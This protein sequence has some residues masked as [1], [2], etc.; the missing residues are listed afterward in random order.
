MSDLSPSEKKLLDTLIQKSLDS[1]PQSTPKSVKDLA[2]T[3]AQDIAPDELKD[4][5]PAT[6]SEIALT[7]WDLSKKRVKNEAEL[8][9][10]CPT[11]KKSKFHKTIID[12]VCDDNSF[13]IDSVIAEVN[14]NNYLIDFLL[15]PTLS[16][17][18]EKDG[19]IK[20]LSR[21][22]DNDRPRQAHVHIQIN[23]ALSEAAI[24]A[25]EE[26]LEEV[27]AD[28]AVVNRDWKPMLSRLAE[29]REAL[30][31]ARTKRP[32]REIEKYCSFLDYLYDNNFTLLAYREYE[33][34]EKDGELKSRTLLGKS[35]GLLSKD[36]KPAFISESK[37]GLPRNLQELRRKLDPVSVSKT[38]RLST[39]H[40]RVPMDAIAIK[41]YDDDG[42]V[43]GEKLFLGLFTSVTY[44]RSVSSVP[45]LREKVEDVIELSDF[46]PGS[47]DR[48]ALR[49]ILEKYPRDELFQIE[50]KQLLKTAVSILRLQEKQRIALFTRKDPFGRYISCLIY[51]PRDR[52]SSELRVRLI[53]ILEDELQGE[54][55]NFYTNMDDSVFARVA[56]TINIKQ[57]KSARLN[58]QE[59]EEKLQE[60]GKTWQEKLSSALIDIYD[61]GEKIVALSER[62]MN[63]FPVSYTSRYRES[64]AVFDIEHIEEALG[65][66]ILGLDLYKPEDVGERQLRL[67]IYNP[68]K[69][70]TLSDI[71]PI[72]DNM[73]LRAI[74]EL[75]Y[76][77]LPK[78][79]QTVW[80]HDFLLEAPEIAKKISIDDVK[81]NFERA[82]TKIWYGE[83]ESDGLNRLI[84]SANMNWH[85][86]T[87]LRTYVRYLKQLRFPLSKPYIEKAL[88]QHPQNSRLLV[89]LFKAYH[90][91][92]NG[93]DSKKRVHAVAASIEKAL[94]D[95]DS[96]DQDRILRTIKEL[97]DA[98]LRTN[99]YQRKDDGTAK[100]YLSVKLQCKDISVLPE[101][102]PYVEIFV[103]SPRV[104]GV[105]LRGD[106]IARGGLRWSDRHEDF[107]TEVLGLMKAQMVKNS[108][109][110]PMGAKGGFIVKK[111]PKE[112]EQ[113]QQE[114]IECYK[115]F[116]RGLLDITDNRKEGKT[117]PPENIVRRD[118]DDPYLVVAADKGTAKF[119]D[120]ANS[121]SEEYDFWLGDAFASGGSVGYDH[122]K[123]G[124]TARG[125][126]ES[127]KAHFRM[128]N[129]NTQEQDFDVVGVGDM[130]GDVFGNG[131]L[132]SRHIRLVAAFNH[133][134]IF[135]DPD[136]DP[137]ASFEE[138]KKLFEDVCGWDS[139]DTDKLSK[140]GRIF[141]RQDK[142]I[143]LT[144]EIKDRFDIKDDKVAPSELIRA[145]LKARTDLL[146]FGG[147]GTYVKSSSET[148]GDVGDKAND[149]IRVN[150]GDL[151]AK[152]VG[153]GANLGFTQLGRIEFA[154]K[155]GHI[156][157][158]FLDNSGGVDC[159]DH[160]V[161]IKILLDDVLRSKKHKLDT[162]ARNKLLEDMTE[163]VA[164]LVL[165]NNYQQAQAISLTACTAARD[166]QLHSEFIQ[167]LEREHSLKRDIEGLPDQEEIEKRLRNGKGLT[168]PELC[169]LMSYAKITFTNALLK[170]Q[171][172]DNPHME[173]WIVNYFPEAIR[174]N[175]E[176][177]I[178]EHE[179]KREIVATTMANSLV[180]RMG[181]TFVKARIK[182]TG[183]KISD[184]AEA[185]ILVRD[186][187]N[188]RETWDK[189]EALDNQVPSQVQLSAMQEICKLTEHTATWF[190]TRLGRSPEIALDVQKYA[191]N[192]A[193]LRKCIPEVA[194]EDLKR[195]I[196]LRT[197]TL[198]NDGLPEELAQQIAIMPALSSA[199]DII[200]VSVKEDADLID[201][202]RTYFE[203]GERFYIEWLRQKARHIKS[204]DHWQTEAV[205]GLI[206]QLYSCQAG[207]TKRILRDTG[208]KA[209]KNQSLFECWS[210]DYEEEARQLEPLLGSIRRS[211]SIDLAMLVIAEQRLRHLYGG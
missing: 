72:L 140:G 154:E 175:Y 129:H 203:L 189:I 176:K 76:E 34:T 64:Q 32:L 24:K 159:S 18:Y 111:P 79:K 1:M 160:E 71:M 74:S 7:H 182:K 21:D 97:I 183:A 186:A 194:T 85:E 210:E 60:A 8:R 14:R 56:A 99:Y 155:G 17:V 80:I 49:H 33:F 173:E 188:L 84:L 98:T 165:R 198:M 52:F 57:S 135:C 89:N 116:I 117:L 75:P 184:I 158:D 120:I 16:V 126:W 172:P 207:M 152:V 193:K 179:L 68:S 197:S 59:L 134:H 5:D 50:D 150:A 2:R 200:N 157:T 12:I 78:Q 93:K 124:I 28:V 144:K 67:K 143:E 30:A 63:A 46:M 6:L 42:K 13:L 211:G 3:I 27:I 92:E 122:K 118:K 137:K 171:L 110:V 77:I 167:D 11:G 169:I 141:S 164:E 26:G 196:N 95:V 139:Y 121:L 25:L 65:T 107:R 153:E 151:R 109:I 36:I 125:A 88:T 38:N 166:L 142:T 187:F 22:I 61:D 108:L 51:I 66:G 127:V 100:D 69:P 123:I 105:H 104:E 115:I 81:K 94:M 53:E 163:D 70:I 40:R 48:K 15:H 201:T 96:L 174:D 39:V 177:E 181:P 101:P 55:G 87:I 9:I 146:W 41:T 148:H 112:R 114:G 168:R 58:M 161:N 136:P 54:C 131:M 180:N 83:M 113:Y 170:S 205:D 138:R 178:F 145:I 185:Y 103:Y 199:C 62:Y 191:A 90:N 31:N 209:G 190:L 204:D 149:A 86:I 35:L 37:E 206:D 91:P 208:C 43:I 128:L 19:N 20:S 102:R 133:L 47:H 44:S 106:K 73:G 23:D 82:F 29:C 45:F 192:I 147:I 195:T 10:I 119:S 4:F 156:N 130:S 202:A 132:L 162:E